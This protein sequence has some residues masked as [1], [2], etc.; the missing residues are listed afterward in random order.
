M[1]RFLEHVGTLSES[2]NIDTELSE[3]KGCQYCHG[4]VS[5]YTCVKCGKV[6]SVK[7][8]NGQPDRI[9]NV[10]SKMPAPQQVRIL[11]KIQ[12]D[13][14]LKED[15]PHREEEQE[16]ELCIYCT[17]R[18][19]T[20]EHAP[21]CS[22]QCAI[23][24]EADNAL[25]EDTIETVPMNDKGPLPVVANPKESADEVS[26][27]SVFEDA[28]LPA[29]E[30]L[31]K[32]VLRAMP[33][34]NSISA[35]QMAEK[36]SMRLP[37]MGPDG[38]ERLR[39]EV[40]YALANLAERN[41]IKR[42]PQDRMGKARF[43]RANMMESTT[44]VEAGKLGFRPLMKKKGRNQH[45]EFPKNISYG[46][47]SWTK[48]ESGGEHWDGA[49]TLG[50]I[51]Y[52]DRY[53]NIL[54]VS[55]KIAEDFGVTRC[56]CPDDS[57]DHEAHD[58]QNDATWLVN[59]DGENMY[60]C[61]DCILSSDRTRE[62]LDHPLDDVLDEEVTKLEYECM[63]CSKPFAPTLSECPS[64]GSVRSKRTMETVDYYPGDGE[65]GLSED[66][67]EDTPSMTVP[68]KERDSEEDAMPK[69][70]VNE[71]YYMIHYTDGSSEKFEG[72]ASQAR[73]KAAKSSKQIDDI[74]TL[75]AG[76]YAAEGLSV[77][78]FGT[79]LTE[80]VWAPCSKC[81]GTVSFTGTCTKC[82]HKAGG[83]IDKPE[84]D[85]DKPKAVK[86]AA[87]SKR[88][89]DFGMKSACAEC[90]KP[91]TWYHNRLEKSYCDEH[92]PQDTMTR[93]PK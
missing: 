43:E 13:K 29:G 28:I 74:E 91:A 60:L 48:N 36:L 69:K 64:C 49:R 56:E 12:A 92:A 19:Q 6:Q 82:G 24:A 7:E 4:K 68:D 31:E 55:N 59:R 3:A 17:E 44:E 21:Y 90:G 2:A 22:S 47:R 26:A 40:S 86:E 87:V 76:E 72:S 62:K 73:A 33:R 38:M 1:K 53:G 37:W 34:K 51:K 23:N 50:G 45:F 5:G 70:P 88:P 89:E 75:S 81:G 83:S 32:L 67:I 80:G 18:P 16:A 10:D 41:L 66:A 35:D 85:K 8:A 84:Y 61:G 79:F 9:N 57:I 93:L 15:H 63:E 58:C 11:K 54:H 14:K 71:G 39:L 20:K 42:V 78:R 30:H 27:G 65:G 25:D 52:A 46:G 77:K